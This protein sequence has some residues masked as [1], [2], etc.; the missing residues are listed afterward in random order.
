M[1]ITSTNS[2]GIRRPPDYS[3]NLCPPQTFAIWLFGGCLGASF[4][5]FSYIKK[6]PKHPLRKSYSRCLRRTQIRWVIKFAVLRGVKN[7]GRRGKSSKTRFFVGNATTIK[8]WMCNFYC[9]EIL[10]SLRRLL[11]RGNNFVILACRMEWYTPPCMS[12]VQHQCWP[13]PR[14]L[15]LQGW[16]HWKRAQGKRTR[17]RSL[18]DQPHCARVP[19]P[20]GPFR[21]KNSTAPESVVFCYCRS[22]LLSVPFSCLLFLEKQAL[23]STIRSVLLPP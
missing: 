14:Q 9:W 5:L 19:P 10:L 7:W 17:Q 23:L 22:F 4:L 21:T 20:K 16:A 13:C 15:C 1:C 11:S 12:W 8:Y 6:G 18:T 3:S 2:R